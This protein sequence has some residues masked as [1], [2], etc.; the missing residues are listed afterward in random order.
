MIKT[1]FWRSDSTKERSERRRRAVI[2]QHF[3]YDEDII[4]TITKH[5]KTKEDEMFIRSALENNDF[6]CSLLQNKKLQDVVDCMYPESVTPNKIIIKEGDKDGSHLYISVTGTYEV[7]QN[8]KV[9]SRFSDVRVFG[10]LALLY[11]ARRL[12]TIRA[13]TSGRLWILDRVVFKHL[14]VQSEMDQHQETVTFLEGVAKLN[15]VPR[16]VLEEVASLLKLEFFA[17]GTNIVEEGDT[18]PDKFYIIKAG[19]VTVSK[20]NE[21]AIDKLYRGSFFGELALLKE[22]VRKATVTA[23]PP[24][25]ECLILTRKEF[26]A[27]FGNIPDCFSINIQ[28]QPYKPMEEII[29]HTDLRLDDFKVVNTLGVGDFGRVELVQHTSKR[30]LVFALKCMEKHAIVTQKHQEDVFNEKKV[31]ISCKNNFIVRLYRTYKDAKYLYFLLEPCLGG[32]LWSLLHKQNPRR[33]DDN[34]AKFYAGCVVEAFAYLHERRIVYRDLKPE[35]LLVD[36]KGY[37]KLTDFGFAK[38][39]QVIKKCVKKTYTFAGTPEYVPPEIILNQGHDEAVDCWALGV[40]V[41]ELLTGK[42]PFATEDSSYM[43]TYKLI[44]KG[45]DDVTFPKHLSPEAESIVKKLCKSTPAQRLGCQNGGVAD[46]KMDD[47]FGGFDW[48]K[49]EECKLPAPFRPNLRTSTDVHYFEKFPKDK[50]IPPDE[51][52]GWDKNF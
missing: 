10:E 29:E 4:K 23:D 5:P 44:L 6:L 24:G 48:Q 14:M 1:P 41:F 34:A 27:H 28:T 45:I 49:L 39:L 19:S 50:K 15:S 33:F 8:D 38:K 18:K 16:E 31:Q 17:T 2:P 43:R 40:F 37:I 13:R 7:I 47:W 3:D 35:N 9:I 21:G 20:K 51:V 42:T 32:D 11:N 36:A 46:I 25:T 22:N 12:A 52:S 26:I 30:E